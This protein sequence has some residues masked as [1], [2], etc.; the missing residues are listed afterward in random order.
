MALEDECKFFRDNKAV[1][2]RLYYRL[3]AVVKD[4]RVV[5]LFP[6]S[7]DA[8]AFTRRTFPEGGAAIMEFDEPPQGFQCKQDGIDFWAAIGCLQNQHCRQGTAA[9]G[10]GNAGGPIG[11]LVGLVE[12]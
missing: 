11:A 3:W 7:W 10:M 12:R 4:R 6:F 9:Q 8:L 5:A 1:L 2:S